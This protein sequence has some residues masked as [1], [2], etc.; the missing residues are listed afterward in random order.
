MTRLV[1]ADSRPLGIA[2][3]RI[4]RSRRLVAIGRLGVRTIDPSADPRETASSSLAAPRL[5]TA[6]TA[7][8]AT[9][10]PK[11][12]VQADALRGQADVGLRP[13]T[14][15]R[16]ATRA[17]RSCSVR[18]ASTGRHA[19]PQGRGRCRS[20]AYHDDTRGVVEVITNVAG[21]A[22]AAS[23]R[24]TFMVVGIAG[25]TRSDTTR[26]AASVRNSATNATAMCRTAPRRG[27]DPRRDHVRVGVARQQH[28]LE[29]HEHGGPD[30]GRP[31]EHRL[32]EPGDHRLGREQEERRQRDRA[33]EHQRR[34]WR[35]RG[36]REG[37][38][39]RR[40]GVG[41]RFWRRRHLASLAG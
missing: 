24:S 10:S 15:R 5:R 3:S 16:A 14:G 25:S 23:T 22:I 41:D 17:T 26:G 19:P 13:G 40:C 6:A 34:R 9:S 20:R 18:T 21:P 39:P 2:A 7:S 12:I 1:T 28:H 4:H 29:E 36:P 32:G 37:P 38:E 27:R 31:A 11:P 30:R 35:R 33:A 8:S